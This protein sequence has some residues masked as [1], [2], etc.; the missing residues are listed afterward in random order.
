[1]DIRE[2]SRES[3]K[4]I[5]VDLEYGVCMCSTQKPRF[6]VDEPVYILMPGYMVKGHVSLISTVIVQLADTKKYFQYD[7]LKEDG[8]KDYDIREDMLMERWEK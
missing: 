7:I 4:T 2:E 6:R 1:M 3:I 5:A 8:Y